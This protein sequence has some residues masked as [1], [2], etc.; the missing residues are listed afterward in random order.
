[1][2]PALPFN[3]RRRIQSV[4]L[5]ARFVGLRRRGY[6]SLAGESEPPIHAL[7]VAWEKFKDPECAWLLVKL[8]PLNGLVSLKGELTPHLAEGWKISRMYLRLA[9]I[10]PSAPEELLATDGVSYCYVMAKLG[11][12][13]PVARAKSILKR[14]ATDERLGLLVWSLGKMQHWEV[15]IWLGK[16]LPEF[17][18]Q[19]LAAIMA[20]HDT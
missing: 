20:R 16:Q 8:L 2:L 17:Q 10:E 15:L 1:M 14:Y 11:R 19:R 18:D 4:F 13:I 7:R 9:E 12:S 5:E 3:E 6:K